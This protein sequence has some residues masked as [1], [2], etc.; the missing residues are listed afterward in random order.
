MDEFEILREL[1]IDIQDYIDQPYPFS[2]MPLNGLRIILCLLQ[3][4]HREKKMYHRRSSG[5]KDE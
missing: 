2:A 5:M 4:V 3:K 1:N